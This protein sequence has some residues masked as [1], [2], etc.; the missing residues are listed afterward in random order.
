[1]HQISQ[2]ILNELM[3]V[4]HLVQ[5]IKVSNKYHINWLQCDLSSKWKHDFNATVN[6]WKLS[7][8]SWLLLPYPYT[9]QLARRLYE[10]MRREAATKHIQK[11]VRAHTARR[12][13]TNL[14]ASAIVIQTGLRAMAA[15]N[16]YKHKRR[17]KATTIIQVI[18]SL[19]GIFL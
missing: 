6:D 12:S 5:Q 14:Q 18:N 15:R 1:M 10:E 8:L 11:H 4:V 17:T 9:A 3:N 7:L 19:V 16:I 2:P 13:Y